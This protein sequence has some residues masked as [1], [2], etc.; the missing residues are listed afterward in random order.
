MVYLIVAC[1]L[2]L[3]T[4]VILG[5]KV[6]LLQKGYDELT[7]D[8]KDQISGKTGVPVTLSTKDRHAVNCAVSLNENIKHLRLEHIKY[9][10][11][12]RT[13]KEAV[14][15]ISHDL[16]TP[17]TAINS[18]LDL[19]EEE[20]DEEVRKQYLARIKNRT[21]ALTDL[22]EE[23]FKY[24]T[25]TD[26]SGSSKEENSSLEVTDM[27][28]AVEECII[29]FYGSLVKRGIE[30]EADPPETEV[31]V[32]CSPR[33]LARILENIISNAIKYTE[34]DL[35]VS[36]S[37]EGRARFSNR[38][39]HLTPVSAARLF[40]RYYTVNDGTESTGLG[41]SIAKEL[42]DKNGGTIGSSVENGVLVIE[43][44]FRRSI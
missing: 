12:N 22:T 29:S 38:T 27:R 32:F 35:K 31:P 39:D 44:S 25:V 33:D 26:K 28:R 21:E 6:V 36:L 16:R 11:G 34:G 13:V 37:P 23:L 7:G 2:L 18:Y 1:I 20:Q 43:L 10:N 15:N 17:L 40:D 30:P 14:T 8:I 3:I 4:A 24:T 19:L 9:E 41:F 42:T 5:I